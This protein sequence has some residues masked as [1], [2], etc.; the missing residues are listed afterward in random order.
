MTDQTD[1]AGGTEP[2]SVVDMLV[3]Q[4]R[5]LIG[6]NQLTVGDQLPTERELCE[7]FGA[8]RNTVREAMRILKAYGIVEV[9]PKVGATIVDNR[10]AS[11]I[12]MFSF[13]VS[14][15]S[16][17]TFADIQGF[18]CLLEVSSVEDLF[19]RITED[20]VSDLRAINAELGNVEDINIASEIDFRF[21]TRLISV[22][23]NKAVLDVYGLMKPVILR[24]M[25]K[26]NNE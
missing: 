12:E 2:S 4:I 25:Q 6:E 9:R 17:Q 1:G 19:E 26:G 15:V 23:R 3:S 24:I 21:H 8:S 18:R 22:L 7:T 13:N 20:D 10:M 14:E 5:G 16:R 11:A